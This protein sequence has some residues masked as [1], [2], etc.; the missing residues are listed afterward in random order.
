MVEDCYVLEVE[1][2]LTSEHQKKKFV[3]NPRLF[4]AQKM[5]DGEVRLE[6]LTP[7][8]RELCRR[9]KSKELN[10]FLSNAAVRKC[11]N[12]LE[13]KES[14]DS[15]CLMGCWVLTWKPTPEEPVEDANAE[16]FTTPNETTFNPDGKKET[17]IRIF[18]LGF[19]HSDLLK[20]G[21]HMSTAFL[22]TL[23][24]EEKKCLWTTGV[25]ELTRTLNIPEMDVMRILKNFYGSTTAPQNLWKNVN[26]SLLSLGAAKIKGDPCFGG[27]LI[28][29]K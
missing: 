3:A 25:Q 10:F 14:R 17:K 13:E 8:L 2:D 15:G 6:K 29:K 16:V 9:A 18:L 20:G 28:L 26:D 19:E 7:H 22:Q 1:F 23:P 12:D 21:Y 4:L 5:R 27:V 24:T 11:K